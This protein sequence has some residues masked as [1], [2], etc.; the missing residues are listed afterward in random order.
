MLMEPGYY[1]VT[2]AEPIVEGFGVVDE[3]M[4]Q[5]EV[6]RFEDLRWYRTGM[7][8]AVADQCVVHVLSPEPLPQP[9]EPHDHR[10]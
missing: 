3:K 4:G 8:G 6:A 1:W 2:V 5:P 7:S 9:T 10:P